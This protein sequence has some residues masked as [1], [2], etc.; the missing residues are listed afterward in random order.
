MAEAGFQEVDNYVSRRQNTV[1]Q[2]IVTEARTKGGNALVGTGGYEFV[3]DT[4][5]GSDREGGGD[6]QDG[7]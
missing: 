2:Y 4:G 5:G 6:G 3:G 7:D 1:A